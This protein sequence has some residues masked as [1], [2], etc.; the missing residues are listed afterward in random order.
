MQIHL[1]DCVGVLV[2]EGGEVE[3]LGLVDVLEFAPE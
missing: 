2:G 3:W 1:L